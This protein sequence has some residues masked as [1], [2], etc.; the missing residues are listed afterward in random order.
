MVLDII[1]NDFKIFHF[2]D[3]ASFY[4][5]SINFCALIISSNLAKFTHSF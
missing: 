4:K 1:I 2:L 5:N 3:V